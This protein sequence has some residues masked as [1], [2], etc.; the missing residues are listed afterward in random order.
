LEGFGVGLI[1]LLLFNYYFESLYVHEYSVFMYVC[2]PC[3][4]LVTAEIRRIYG[5][6]ETEV[7]RWFWTTMWML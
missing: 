6:P 7:Y 2:V 5:I 4:Y 3:A 1:L